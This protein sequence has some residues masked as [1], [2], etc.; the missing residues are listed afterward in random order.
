MV[1]NLSNHLLGYC[2]NKDLTKNRDQ[3]YDVSKVRNTETRLAEG[4]PCVSGL[5]SKLVVDGQ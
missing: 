3:W 2:L 1:E 4:I 5:L